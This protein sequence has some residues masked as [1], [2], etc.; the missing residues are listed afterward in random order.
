[1]GFCHLKLEL[2]SGYNKEVAAI[3]TCIYTGP[4]LAVAMNFRGQYCFM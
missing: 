1:M 4:G 3:H 2:I